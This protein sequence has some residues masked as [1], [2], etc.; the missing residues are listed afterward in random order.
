[1]AHLHAIS[2]CHIDPETSMSTLC[3]DRQ[4]HIW[5]SIQIMPWLILSLWNQA[6]LQNWNISMSTVKHGNGQWR[7]SLYEV[8]WPIRVADHLTSAV[9]PCSDGNRKPSSSDSFLYTLPH[10]T[11]GNSAYVTATLKGP[12]I[13]AHSGK[14]PMLRWYRAQWLMTVRHLLWM[15]A[16]SFSLT[17]VQNHKHLHAYNC[18]QMLLLQCWQ[19][20]DIRGLWLY[21]PMC[22]FSRY[23]TWWQL[24]RWSPIWRNIPS[25]KRPW[26]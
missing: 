2:V 18:T 22:L 25:P 10:F 6:C 15:M 11:N 21:K 26:R 17:L 16:S 4:V 9:S 12:T 14:G 7:V 20:Y 5:K 8:V 1:M 23:A 24:W 19:H 3:L 13:F